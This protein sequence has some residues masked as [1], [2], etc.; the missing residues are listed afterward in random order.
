MSELEDVRNECEVVGGDLTLNVNL[1]GLVNLDGVRRVTGD[2]SLIWCNGSGDVECP[3]ESATGVTVSSSSLEEVG[4]SLNMGSSPGVEKILLPRL[5]KVGDWVKG[6]NGHL[7]E[8]DISNL[9]QVRRLSLRFVTKLET[10][11]I[12]SLASI[13]KITIQGASELKRIISNGIQNLT[14]GSEEED[15]EDGSTDWAKANY[16][17]ITDCPKLREVGDLYAGSLT[18]HSDKE[19]RI[20]LGWGQNGMLH[21][22]EIS[23]GWTNTSLLDI[24]GVHDRVRFGNNDT[25]SM[26]IERALAR[27]GTDFDRAENLKNLSLGSLYLEALGG[28]Y[29]VD[30]K[31]Q[32]EDQETIQLEFDRVREL[33]VFT[34]N[35][36][37]VEKM[38]LPERVQTW[39]LKNLTLKMPRTK[40]LTR[41][42][43]A[44]DKIIWHWP[45]HMQIVELEGKIEQDLL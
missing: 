13:D 11:N 7:T 36:V 43:D 6:F 25:G 2:L 14:R 15:E 45:E 21:L 38:S 30:G 34:A 19:L 35:E 40:F 26:Y 3:V 16:I 1:T 9:K 24:R 20:L 39:G 32:D 27:V 29:L 4:G 17:A 5:V 8:L 37:V 42:E 41:D 22:E 10:L 33:E 12:T 31:E 44:D 23:L 28:T 18:R